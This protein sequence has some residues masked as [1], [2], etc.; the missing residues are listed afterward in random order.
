[1][2]LSDPRGFVVG[3]FLPLISQEKLGKGPQRAIHSNGWG[4]K[5]SR[6]KITHSGISLPGPHPGAMPGCKP[7]ADRLPE[8][9][10][11]AVLLL[12][13]SSHDS[14][15]IMR[16]ISEHKGACGTRTP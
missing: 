6:G 12:D 11:S 10:H 4:G 1:M 15:S 7:E 14:L 2:C 9:N 8:L 16:T 13:F 3:G 5:K